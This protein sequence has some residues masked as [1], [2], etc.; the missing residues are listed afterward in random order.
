MDRSI[1]R[2]R[3]HRPNPEYRPRDA[4][5]S[6][7]RLSLDRDLFA[8][9]HRWTT[10]RGT[11]GFAAAATF[12]REG[13]DPNASAETALESARRGTSRTGSHRMPEIAQFDRQFADRCSSNSRLSGS[14]SRSSPLVGSTSRGIG[15][16][17][18]D[19]GPI[20]GEDFSMPDL[21]VVRAVR[22]LGDPTLE[23]SRVSGVNRRYHWY[24][25]RTVRR[26]CVSRSTAAPVRGSCSVEIS[27]AGDDRGSASSPPP[28]YLVSVSTLVLYDVFSSRSPAFL[29]NGLIARCDASVISFR[30]SAESDSLSQFDT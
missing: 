23:P 4:I 13:N 8:R 27:A 24:Y 2:R 12:D 15:I 6:A 18:V 20:L 14:S 10:V 1:R 11:T 28:R 26:D 16:T 19:R 9:E 21:L 25:R 29:T 17:T 5:G 22:R 3:L 7:L 30:L